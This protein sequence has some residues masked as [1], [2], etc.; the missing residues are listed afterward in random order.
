MGR[1]PWRRRRRHRVVPNKVGVF[2]DVRWNYYGERFGRG[3]INNFAVRAGV[4][5]VF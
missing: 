4:R 2:S 5:I 3:D 1:R